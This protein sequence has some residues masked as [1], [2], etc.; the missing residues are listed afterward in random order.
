MLTKLA[1]AG[2]RSIRELCIELEQINIITGANGSG[3]SS[4]YRALRL[5]AD[6][7][8]GRII[9]SLAQ[10]G[11]LSSTLWAGPET[12][13]RAMKSGEHPIQGGRRS[14][15]VS[16]K[17]GFSGE[18]YGYAID[19]GLPPPTP[20]SMFSNDPQIKAESLWGGQTIG[21]H[22]E[23]A[24]RKSPSVQVK[25]RAGE[26]KQASVSI[27]PADSMM[28]LS[29]DPYD[30]IEL[31]ILRETMRNWRFYDHL[32]TDREAQARFP[33]VGTFTPVLASDGSDFC[34]AIQT[35]FEIGDGEGLNTAIEDAFPKSRINIVNNN[36]YFEL[37]IKQH[38]L[39]RPLKSAELSDGTLRYLLLTAALHSPRP[40]RLM[41]LN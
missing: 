25:S 3:K 7:A 26:W 39:L 12:I 11:G 20:P 41:I 32:R 38:G 8:Q 2:Y 30:G 14:N 9:Q 37:E 36:G 19:V 17:L 31:L 27:S 13:S 22:N 23:I 29:S 35:I 6:V 21:R 40:P 15:P 34:A 24:S 33:Q 5:L 4:L 1:I 16:L 28:A 18:D 10:E